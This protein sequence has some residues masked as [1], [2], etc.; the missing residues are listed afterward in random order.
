MEIIKSD[1]GKLS[2]TSKII[3]DVFGKVHRN[4]LA[5]IRK[6]DCSEEFREQHYQPSFYV[7]PQNKKISCYNITKDGFYF[8]C[9][10]FTGKKA[11]KWKESFIK[12]FN[13]MESGL[14]NVDAEMTRLSKQGNDIKSL[15]SEWS[16]F[17]HKINK[18]KKVHEIAV[19]E[20]INKVQ[21]KLDY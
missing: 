6:L 21:L 4:V 16:K 9:M 20:L 2:T 14:L 7:S 18:Q 12:A 17:G 5:D 3:C 19:N 8:L 1:N 13:E 10:G 11:A 15:G